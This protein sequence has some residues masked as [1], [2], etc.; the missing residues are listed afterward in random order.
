MCAAEAGVRLPGR[1][2]MT[3]CPHG[4]TWIVAG[5]FSPACGRHA[6]AGRS[7]GRR[8]DRGGSPA[9]RAVECCGLMYRGG[10]HDGWLVLVCG[11][12]A[13]FLGGGLLRLACWLMSAPRWRRERSTA[14][15][16]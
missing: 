3:Y 5:E 7:V 12:T 10:P 9:G 1:A 15:F 8:R 4:Q 16:G 13:V 14:R 2:T 11:T 6:A